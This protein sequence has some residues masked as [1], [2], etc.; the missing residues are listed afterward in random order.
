[1]A[2]RRGGSGGDG[3]SSFDDSPWGYEIQLYGD[4]FHD[5]T[6]RALIAII[7]ICFV[8][9]IAIAIGAIFARTNS[10]PLRW[11]LF[12][13][14]IFMS[15]IYLGN[16]FA[17]G[18]LYEQEATVKVVYFLIST[19]LDSSVYLAEISLL[20]FIYI[21]I[22]ACLHNLGVKASIKT[23]LK[24]S[25]SVIISILIAFW[26]AILALQIEYQVDSVIHPENVDIDR[27]YVWIKLEIAYYA[28]FAFAS[29][30]L[31][32]L[33][34]WIIFGHRKQDEPTW[35]GTCIAAIVAMPLL[36]R[37]LVYLGIVAASLTRDVKDEA[38]VAITYIAYISFILAYIGVLLVTMKL[39]REHSGVQHPGKFG[40]PQMSPGT[41]NNAAPV[42][43]PVYPSQISPYDASNRPGYGNG[44]AP[45]GGA[46]YWNSSPG[47]P[48]QSSNDNTAGYGNPQHPKTDNVN[49]TAYQ[50]QNQHNAQ[51]SPVSPSQQQS[52][53][54][55]L[56]R[57]NSPPT[58]FR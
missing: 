38:Q 35:I 30:E 14:S 17:A 23:I 2:P 40:P 28:V 46:P 41:W 36:V 8:A 39:K 58:N 42:Q 52:P 4:H 15:I 5:P 55:P 24:I 34:V 49:V 11:S 33:G 13:F 7:G 12:F 47:G 57:E 21:V 9:T 1:M 10:R 32:A 43:H 50:L 44:T 25:S 45:H 18:I 6:Q 37:S 56:L 19:I 26:A 16:Y 3:S 22:A 48:Q 53:V 51:R 29:V 20:G 31:V 54:S 27:A